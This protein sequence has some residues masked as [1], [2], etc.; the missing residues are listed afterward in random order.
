MG[1]EA[2]VGAAVLGRDGGQLLGRAGRI[3]PER[4]RRRRRR[5]AP[6][7]GRPG[8]RARARGARAG[9][10]R[11]PPAAAGRPSRRRR[12]G[13]RRCARGARRPRPGGRRGRAARRRRARCGRRPR[14]WRR[15]SSAPPRPQVLE[16]GDA[17]G[18]PHEAAA[19]MGGRA[20]HPQAVHRR[21]VAGPA[22]DGPVEEELLERQLALE[23]VALG[24]A[25]P[26]PRCR[27][28]RAPA[29]RRS[30]RGC[31]EPAR[32]ACRSRCRGTPAGARRPTRRRR[33]GGTARTGRSSSSRA[34]RAAPSP[35]RPASG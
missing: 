12:P 26:Q 23:D 27:G 13:C 18:G 17:A 21:P 15:S 33:R 1:V 7:C 3:G 6:A 22:G 20:A 10:P 34:C 31:W 5:A 24:E 11:R 30:G 9:A 29:R 28:A 2:R 19:G 8:A 35:G 14:R 25:D 4:E 16:G 32:P